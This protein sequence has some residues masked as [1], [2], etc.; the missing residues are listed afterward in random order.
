MEEERLRKEQKEYER[1]NDESMMSG[2]DYVF[3]GKVEDKYRIR[4]G[5]DALIK[6]KLEKKTF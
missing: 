4:S 3:E 2:P 5:K 1:L 6:K